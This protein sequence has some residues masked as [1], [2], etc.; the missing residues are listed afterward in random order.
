MISSDLKGISYESVRSLMAVTTL[1]QLWT[2][3]DQTLE[4]DTAIVAKINKEKA[5][6]METVEADF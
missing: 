3:L 2:K 5:F 1:T 4:L 6:K